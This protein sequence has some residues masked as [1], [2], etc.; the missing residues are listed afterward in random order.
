MKGALVHP[1]RMTDSL[2]NLDWWS[3]PGRSLEVF[4][5]LLALLDH[6]GLGWHCGFDSGRNLFLWLGGKRFDA[7]ED[8][9]RV[10][11]ELDIGYPRQIADRDLLAECAQVA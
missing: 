7:D 11:Q 4:F 9:I 5:F 10:R 3:R 8:L 1:F 6:F 2:S